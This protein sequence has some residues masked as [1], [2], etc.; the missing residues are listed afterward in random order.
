MI[1]PVYWGI[2]PRIDPEYFCISPFNIGT[3]IAS[4]RGIEVTHRTLTWLNSFVFAT[5]LRIELRMMGKCI[6]DVSEFYTHDYPEVNM[7]V[8]YLTSIILDVTHN[9]PFL[10]SCKDRN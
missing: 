9:F 4:Q 10:L 3:S 2:S 5:G 7:A 1:F 8:S 6:L